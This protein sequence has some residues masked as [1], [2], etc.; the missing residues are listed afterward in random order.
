MPRKDFSRSPLNVWQNARND[1]SRKLA[2]RRRARSKGNGNGVIS[3]ISGTVRR[4]LPAACPGR[5]TRSILAAVAEGD[6]D[7]V[8]LE[9]LMNVGRE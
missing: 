8:M 7:I 1:V 9:G 3:P 4:S 5:P 6:S 2:V